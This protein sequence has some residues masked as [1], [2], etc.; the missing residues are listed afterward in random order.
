MYCVSHNDRREQVHRFRGR[1][2][3]VHQVL[4]KITEGGKGVSAGHVRWQGGSR[5]NAGGN[6]FMST[7]RAMGGVQ[8]H[9]YVQSVCSLRTE[10]GAE[11][12][13]GDRNTRGRDKITQIPVKTCVLDKFHPGCTV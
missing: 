6:S 13:S 10:Y 5:L 12:M 11:K 3:A 4:I 8:R 1:M 2:R 9:L 7:W